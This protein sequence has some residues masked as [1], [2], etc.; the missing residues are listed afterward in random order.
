MKFHHVLRRATL[1]AAFLTSGLPLTSTA[2]A[3]WGDLTGQFI[4]DGDVPAPD[5]VDST[6]E[7]LCAPKALTDELVINKDNKG[8]IGRAHV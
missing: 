3:Q 6:K 7:P 1:V 8:K 5:E 2:Q 4:F